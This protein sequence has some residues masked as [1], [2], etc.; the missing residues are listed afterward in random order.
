MRSIHVVAASCLLFIVTIA[1]AQ[2]PADSNPLLA[3]SA[4]HMLSPSQA[5]VLAVLFDPVPLPPDSAPICPLPASTT[6]NATMP[7]IAS[8]A[9]NLPSAPDPTALPNSSAEPA[10]ARPVAPAP[11]PDSLKHVVLANSVMYGATFFHAFGH[12]SEVQACIQE[13]GLKNGAF[14]SGPYKGQSPGTQARFYAIALPIDAGVSMLSILA[15]HKGWHAV[16]M[17]APLSAAT[18]HVTAGAFELA[19]GCY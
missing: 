11:R 12:Q 4:A 8:T 15:R 18:A 16:E 14:A 3:S 19:A 2:E 6:S 17:F 7:V 9:R 10:F 1:R 5:A 13:A